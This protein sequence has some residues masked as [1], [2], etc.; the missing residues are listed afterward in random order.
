MT[1]TQEQTQADRIEAKLDQL[2]EFADQV[3][4]ALDGFAS[5]PAAKMF[6]AM[7]RGIGAGR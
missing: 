1:S 5:G 3:K 6:A 2:I 7:A 4:K